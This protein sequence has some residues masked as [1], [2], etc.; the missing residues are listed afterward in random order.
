MDA[1]DKKNEEMPKINMR[2][3][4]LLFA[5]LFLILSIALGVRFSNSYF[6]KNTKTSEQKAG[7]TVMTTVMPTHAA[8]LQ[9]PFSKAAELR[10]LLNSMEQLHVDLTLIALQS[11]Y[12]GL[13]LGPHDVLA[14]A[15]IEAAGKLLD[16]NSNELSGAIGSI[17]GEDAGK[18]FLEIWR[19][20]VSLFVNYANALK[21]NYKDEQTKLTD[22]IYKNI[23]DI[24]RFISSANPNLPFDAVHKLLTEHADLLKTSLDSYASGDYQ[25]S[26]DVQA[27]A[28]MQI[29][30]VADGMAGAIVKQF[31][32]KF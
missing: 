20:H 3:L 7:N 9:D 6:S 11:K 23:E 22:Q 21:N 18:K 19:Q 8:H 2:R 14:T 17:Y 15:K 27:Q 12:D 4:S 5:S 10:V 28:N 26:Y 30:K 24:S 16:K 32:E 25:K 13:Y 29:G 31:P 1:T